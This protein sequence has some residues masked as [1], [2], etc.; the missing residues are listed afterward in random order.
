MASNGHLY[1]YA[2]NQ[3]LTAAGFKGLY[4]K[5][6]ILF[7][8]V[9]HFRSPNL[10]TSVEPFKERPSDPNVVAPILASSYKIR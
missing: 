3:E 8:L 10:G 5:S 2:T 7:V 1:E 4:S 6:R 9:K